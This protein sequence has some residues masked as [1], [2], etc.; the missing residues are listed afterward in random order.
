MLNGLA[1]DVKNHPWF[2]GIDWIALSARKVEPPRKP[3][4]DSAKRL[5]ELQASLSIPMSVARLRIT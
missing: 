3:K 5:K 2:T 4:E 1:N